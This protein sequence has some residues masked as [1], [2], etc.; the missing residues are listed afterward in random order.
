MSHRIAFTLLA[1]FA[2]ACLAAPASAIY[3]S[4][5]PQKCTPTCPCSIV[6]QGP[7]GPTTCGQA[8]QQCTGLVDTSDPVLSPNMT[9]AEADAD[10]IFLLQLQAQADQAPAAPAQQTAAD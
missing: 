9:S 5:C 7:F 6:C 3:I 2:V 10:Q 1:V 8:G 4:D